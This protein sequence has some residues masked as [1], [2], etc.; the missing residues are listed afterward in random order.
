MLWCSLK[1]AILMK[2]GEKRQ[3]KTALAAKAATHV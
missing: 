1:I 2:N 3:T